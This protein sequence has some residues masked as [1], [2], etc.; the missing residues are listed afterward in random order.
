MHEVRVG[1]S[2]PTLRVIQ[3]IRGADYHSGKANRRFQFQK[4]SQAFH[5]RE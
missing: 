3:A 5:P 1:V 4:R 2:S